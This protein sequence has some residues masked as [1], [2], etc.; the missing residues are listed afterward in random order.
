MPDDSD[1]NLLKRKQ[2]NEEKLVYQQFIPGTQSGC[3]WFDHKKSPNSK[4]SRQSL[5]HG[6]WQR[7]GVE[8]L[9]YFPYSTFF[10]A[11]N[12]PWNIPESLSIA[13]SSHSQADCYCPGP[14][15][16]YR[17]P[18]SHVPLVYAVSLIFFIL[19]MQ[20]KP[21]I[22]LGDDKPI[23]PQT[24]NSKPRLSKPRVDSGPRGL[25]RPHPVA[26]HFFIGMLLRAPR[27]NHLPFGE[28]ILKQEQA[29]WLGCVRN[30][31]EGRMRNEDFCL[32]RRQEL[33]LYKSNRIRSRSESEV[34]RTSS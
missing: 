6:S 29:T 13:Y 17:L 27:F 2:G 31:G 10:T 21:L 5:C 24:E 8:T 20:Q 34:S 11:K 30:R 16:K 1:R 28:L 23:C 18:C 26:E 14:V 7:E 3:L 19:C 22:R 9:F 32:L 12:W 4:T 33:S 15:C 25:P